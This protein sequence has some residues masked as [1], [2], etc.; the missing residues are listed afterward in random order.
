MGD[1][2]YSL[3][4]LCVERGLLSEDDLERALKIQR[5][6][7]AWRRLG[8]VL[9]A[10]GLITGVA[11]AKVLAAQQALRRQLE[12]REAAGGGAAADAGGVPGASEAEGAPA[13]AEPALEP[14][15]P[16]T[17]LGWLLQEARAYGANAIVI[18]VGH[19]PAFRCF[20]KTAL[21]QGAPMSHEQI[22]KLLTDSAPPSVVRALD[23]EGFVDAIADMASGDR[24]RFTLY[25]CGNSFGGTIRLVSA[26]VGDLVALGLPPAVRELTKPRSGLVLVTGPSGSGKT[27]TLNALLDVIN[28]TRA[29]HILTIERP[30]ETF[31]E[32]KRAKL[33]RREVG[34]DSPGYAE[35]LR[36]ALR[37]DA[38][39]IAV[40]ELSDPETIATAVGAAETGHLVLA[41]MHT[42]NSF[43][44][45]LRILDAF[46]ARRAPFV[47]SLLASCLRGIVTQHLFPPPGNT[48][49]PSLAVELLLGTPGVANLI[50]EDRAHQIPYIV[51]TSK[52]EGMV[53]LDDSLV[54]LVKKGRISAATALDHAAEPERLAQALGVRRETARVAR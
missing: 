25:R 6:G 42:G 27:T 8:D 45:I 54:R 40:A 11:L 7:R 49:T 46:P 5:E 4:S 15:A 30:V 19:P 21:C 47:R 48:A 53:S 50:R 51:Q 37:A 31:L 1:T 52:A 28:S 20:G 41:T 17:E 32:P 44:T 35:A 9:L 18:G 22:E 29:C 24:A 16:Q 3:G 10:E 12:A 33:T 43:Q 36:G 26:T 14:G 23:Q 34:R 2:P 39:V 38:D 13:A